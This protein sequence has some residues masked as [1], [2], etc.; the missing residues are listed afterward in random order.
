MSIAVI[1]EKGNLFKGTT[2]T[3]H[4][5]QVIL[6]QNA[7]IPHPVLEME[8]AGIAGVAA[9]AGIPLVSIRS[10]SDNPQSP[11]PIDLEAAMDENDNLQIGRLVTM[12][13]RNPVI[14]FQSRKMI[15]NSRIAADHAA[16]A[17]K[18]LLGEHSII[19]T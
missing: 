2:I 3:T 12:A 17:V 15:K 9:E 19:A 16:L 10:I 7:G 4:G 13:L 18:T 5:S 11:I 6:Q 1:A 8:T 14:I